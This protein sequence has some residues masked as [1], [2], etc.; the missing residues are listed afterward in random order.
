[1][2]VERL[3]HQVQTRIRKE[4]DAGYKSVLDFGREA[5]VYFPHNIGEYPTKI[6]PQAARIIIRRFTSPSDIIL[7][8]FCGAG[9]IAVEAKLNGRNSINYDI[10][11]VAVELCRKKLDAV[12]LLDKYMENSCETTHSVEVGDARKLPLD[13]EC[14]DA[15]IT[16]IPYAS[17]IK[18][19][20]LPDDL[21]TIE[22]YN[23]FLTEISKAFGE[24][25]RVL[26]RGKYCVIFVCDYRVAA[27]RM[28][29]PVH[30]DVTNI[31]RGI[32][33]VIF[34]TYIWRYYRSGGFRPF[35]SKPYQAMNVHSYILVFYKP[36]GNE[37]F[38][39]TNRPVRYRPRLISKQRAITSALNSIQ[40]SQVP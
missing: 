17:M 10:N 8:Q 4:R 12:N 5:K 14:V 36:T 33:F 25:W 30:T 26:K 6:L 28:I 22:D 38:S 20:N 2:V 19:S 15:V 21:S 37:D 29:L 3:R 9:T 34:D 13:D 31:M 16:D 23:T 1:M 35:G 40:T 24:M 39:R 11:P 7:D 32:G 18:Y 27:S